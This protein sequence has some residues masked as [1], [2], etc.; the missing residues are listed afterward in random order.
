[1]LLLCLWRRASGSWGA[2]S[3]Y[4]SRRSRYLRK[5]GP[6]DIFFYGGSS[7]LWVNHG[8]LTRGCRYIYNKILLFCFFDFKIT[9]LHAAVGFS[10][11]YFMKRMP[12]HFAT[13]KVY[14]Y[15][16]EQYWKESKTKVPHASR[17]LTC[18]L[19]NSSRSV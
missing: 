8:D 3:D 4:I 1:M 5:S 12:H 11:Y 17:R 19:N 16:N 18:L 2:C 7:K 9:R 6:Y 14:K 10:L 15:D 13:K